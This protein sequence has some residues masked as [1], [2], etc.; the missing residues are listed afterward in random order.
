MPTQKQ[1]FYSR[2]LPA[3]VATIT[4]APG[5]LEVKS[6]ATRPGFAAWSAIRCL[7]SDYRFTT[8]V[9]LDWQDNRLSPEDADNPVSGSK[10]GFVINADL[11]TTDPKPIYVGLIG[12]YSTANRWYWSRARTGYALGKVVIGPEGIVMGNI[13]FD[14]QRAGGF[15]SFPLKISSRSLGVTFSG[16]Y[17][18]TGD[19]E[20][21][22][23]IIGNIGGMGNTPYGGVN[24]YTVF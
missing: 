21:N 4:R 20:E 1:D 3:L 11:E 2:A 12:Q 23:E 7:I 6:R 18:W 24:I 14:A 5:F 10:T 8:S 17:Q 19:D 13:G 22:G 16:G 9:G 15:L